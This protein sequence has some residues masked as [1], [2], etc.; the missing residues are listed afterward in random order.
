MKLRRLQEM[1]VFDIHQ[2]R[3]VAR[4]DRA[5]LGDSFDLA[6][7]VVE[8]E[9]GSP[10][11]ISARDFSLGDDAVSIDNQERIKSYACG[12]E[13]SMYQKKVG[14]LVYA[15]DGSELGV[16]TDFVLSPETGVLTAVEISSGAIRDLLEGRR[17]VPLECVDWKT[18]V[19]AM[20]SPEGSD[21]F[22]H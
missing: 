14:D 9:D 19:S 18:A 12:E 20:V 6:Y 17:E 7:L 4:V 16:V 8:R 22:D 1:P 15:G 21:A 2:A 10:G 3:V 13:L 11:M 5:V